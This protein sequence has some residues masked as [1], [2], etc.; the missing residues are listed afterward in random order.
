MIRCMFPRV[1]ENDSV[2]KLKGYRFAGIVWMSKIED[3]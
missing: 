3:E 1:K 2:R